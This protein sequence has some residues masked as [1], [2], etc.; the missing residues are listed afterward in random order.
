MP[1]G[2]N[3]PSPVVKKIRA[4]FKKVVR[5][6]KIFADIIEPKVRTSKTKPADRARV[7]ICKRLMT[8][9]KALRDAIRA[10][11][12]KIGVRPKREPI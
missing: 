6:N 11:F 12:K 3:L 10:E 9:N 7:I 1:K 8:D 4:I 5:S 2:T